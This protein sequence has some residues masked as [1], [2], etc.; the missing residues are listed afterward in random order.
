MGCGKWKC[1]HAHV[2]IYPASLCLLV[3]AIN[4]FTL[5]Q[6]LTYGKP[7]VFLPGKSHRVAWQT[8][9]YG[10]TRVGHDPVTKQQ[11]Q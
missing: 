7:L 8:R 3:G 6:L 11:Q 1:I 9:V 10:V 2:F 4:P 5:R